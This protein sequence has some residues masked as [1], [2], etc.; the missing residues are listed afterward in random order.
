MKGERSVQGWKT[1][2]QNLQLF[3]LPFFQS[4]HLP[5]FQLFGGLLFVLACGTVRADGPV[6]FALTNAR[7]VTVSGP[8]LE[9]GTVLLRDG[10]IEAVG[11]DVSVPAD[12]WVIDAA[13]LTIYPGLIDALTDLGLPSQQQPAQEGSQPAGL[14]PPAA[15]STARRQEKPGMTPYLRAADLLVD[16][17][18]KA[19]DARNAGITTVLTAPNHRGIFLGQSAIINLGEGDESHRVVR[20]PVALHIRLSPMAGSLEFPRSLMGVLAYVK[21]SVYDS[22]HYAEAWA[23]YKK[24][25]RGAKRP[26]TDR[27]LEALEP[28]VRSEMPVVLSASSAVEIQRAMDLADAFHLTYILAGGQEA[29]KLAPVLKRK[30]IPILVSLNFPEKERDSHPEEEEPLRVLRWRAETPKNPAR[31]AE[32]GVPFAFYSDGINNAKHFVRNAARAVR[33]GLSKEAALRA[34]TLGAAEILGVDSQLGSIEPGKIANLVLTTGDLFDEKT[35]IR[36]V[37]VDGRRYEPVDVEQGK[38]AEGAGP[39]AGGV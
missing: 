26:E 28:A 5:F 8:V 32:E 39:E 12:A 17:G 30:Q 7:V 29:Y 38:P 25:P 35:K 33:A 21:Q 31:L 13:G 4:S 19:E 23:V 36:Y 22:R 16:P 11:A 3:V 1:G 27:S 9:K 24:N 18:R 10:L 14:H 37:F 20:S 34:M 15:P 6:I 2:N